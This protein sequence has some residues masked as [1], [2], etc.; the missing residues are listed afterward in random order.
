MKLKTQPTIIEGQNSDIILLKSLGG[1]KE[2]K[3]AW[4]A[5]TLQLCPTHTPPADLPTVL[6]L[7]SVCHFSRVSGKIDPWLSGSQKLHKS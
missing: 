5:I 7:N 2:A 3:G 1:D 4:G 6:S